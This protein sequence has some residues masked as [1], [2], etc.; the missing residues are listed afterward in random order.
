M[1]GCCNTRLVE[2]KRDRGKD[3]DGE[4]RRDTEVSS[5]EL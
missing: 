4:Q 5:A 1:E 3:Q 2:E